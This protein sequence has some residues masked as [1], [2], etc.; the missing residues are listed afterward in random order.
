MIVLSL[1]LWMRLVNRKSHEG[2]KRG[3]VIA[4]IAYRLCNQVM[5][6]PDLQTWETARRRP[7]W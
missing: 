4:K 1:L 5:I 2:A 3:D 7:A 6:I